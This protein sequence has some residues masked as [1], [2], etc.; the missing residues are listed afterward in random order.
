MTSKLLVLFFVLCSATSLR[1]QTSTFF[2]DPNTGNNAADGAEGTPFLSLTFAL[3]QTVAGDTIRLRAGTYSGAETFPIVPKNGVAVEAFPEEQ[4]VFDGGGSG[5]LFRVNQNITL[6]TSLRGLVIAACRIGLDIPAGI[7]VDGLT[8]QECEFSGFVDSAVGAN[9]GFGILAVL[10]SGGTSENLTIDRCSFVGA[11]AAAGI[12]L[13]VNGTTVLDGGGILAN[14]STGGMDRTLWLV[15]SSGGTVAATFQVNDNV[16]AG[17][18]E[19]GIFMHA[20]GGGPI[21]SVATIA[22]QANGNS[23]TGSGALEIGYLLRAQHGVLSQSAVLSP[24]ITYSKITGNY[25]NIFCDAINNGGSVVDILADFYANRIE[26]GVRAGV[27]LAV[28]VPAGAN[29]NNDPNF[30]AGHTGRFAGLNTFAG[31]ITDFRIGG[32]ITNPIQA[33]FNFFPAGGATQIGG[34]PNTLG[35][36]SE[37]IHGGFAHS[38]VADTAVEVQLT[39]AS[40]SAFVDYA[41]TSPVGQIMVTIDGTQLDPAAIEELS[42]GSGLT[43]QL[44]ALALGSKTVLVTNPGGQ[45]GSFLLSV[46]AAGSGSNPATANNCFVATAAYG[47]Y[48]AR[49]VVALRRFRDQY[50]QASAAGREVIDWY[51]THGPSGAA[52]LLQHESLRKATR[53]ALALPVVVANGTTRW[54]PGQRFACGVLLLGV[55]F[56]LT[57]RRV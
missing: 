48:S 1:A 54:N 41:G 33:R 13:E 17:Y 19:A 4:P 24:W 3:T 44:P 53:V 52:F 38:V 8:I 16:F 6:A 28:L 21:F 42:F 34:V 11:G 22:C 40:D 35:I 23:L 37:I 10:S 14:T 55:F 46:V 31:N 25:I 36:L 32:G 18:S 12:A 43:L 47:D 5:T 50:L 45:T 57:K 26:D 56:G 29:D 27:E 30:G 51:Y 2:V 20:L 39:A 9:D 7:G 49:E 15:A